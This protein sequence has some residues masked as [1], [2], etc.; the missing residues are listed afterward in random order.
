MLRFDGGV[1]QWDHRSNRRVREPDL[2]AERVIW[3]KVNEDGS[4]EKVNDP[5]LHVSLSAEWQRLDRVGTRTR[6]LAKTA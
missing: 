4:L 1:F 3:S 5:K 6:L 2:F